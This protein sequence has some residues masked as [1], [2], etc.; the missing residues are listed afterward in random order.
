MKNIVKGVI[1]ICMIILMVTLIGCAQRTT[2]KISEKMTVAVSIVPQETFVKA[3][4]GDLVN[5]VTL[6]PPGNSPA[7]YAPTPRE[8]EAF[9]QASL[10]FTIGTP[11]EEANILPKAKELNENMTVVSLPEEVEKVYPHRYF[12]EA[13]VHKEDKHEHGGDGHHHE[14]GD[15]ADGSECASCSDCQQHEEGSHGHEGDKH[16]HE[17]GEDGHHHEG[18][19]DADGSE[20]ACSDCQQHEEGSHGHEEDKH[21]HEHGGDGHHHEGE[22][23][24]DGSEHAS[25]SD[26]HQH[27]GRDPHIWLSP[28]RVKVMVEVI[29]E[30]LSAVDTKNKAIYEK[31]AKAYIE[32]L[33]QLDR[34][35]KDVL[36]PLKNKT[37]MI[38]H[39]SLGY[40]ADDY[41]L[42]MIAL[43][44]DGKEATA[45][46]LQA[47]IDKAKKENIKVIF[48]QAEIDSK[49]TE[50]FAREIGGKV[51][52]IEPLS[53]HYIENMGKIADTFKNVLN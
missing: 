17:H 15:D 49:Q 16:G 27:G 11:A 53:P 48:Y 6:I 21:G 2:G 42:E 26:C 19:N 10:Y 4:A 46:Q 38:Y 50:T 32:K 29:A 22:D 35:I 36:S 5:I 41:G 43:E 25:C 52:Q 45:K 14:G 28:K 24:A 39:P 47:V 18:E 9:H 34:D 20:C 44:K 33:D 51:V 3:V 40:F 1:V 7:N 12:E 37:F 23:D 8:M 30:E 13:H 31:N